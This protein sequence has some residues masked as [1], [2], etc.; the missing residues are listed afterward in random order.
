MIYFFDFDQVIF[1]TIRVG[2]YFNNLFISLIAELELIQN[3]I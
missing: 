1:K 2:L 3:T